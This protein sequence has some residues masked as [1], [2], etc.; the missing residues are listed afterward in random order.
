[1]GVAWLGVTVFADGT[2]SCHVNMPCCFLDTYENV[3]KRIMAHEMKCITFHLNE[4]DDEVWR[5]S[6]GCLS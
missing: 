2:P 3:L 5:K 1:M 6:R 4:V